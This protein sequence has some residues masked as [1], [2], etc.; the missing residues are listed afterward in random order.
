[1]ALGVGANTAIFSVVNAVLLRPLPYDQGDQLVVLHHGHGDALANDMGF[2][3]K[4]IGDYRRGRSFTD[5]V[6]FHQ[7]FFNLLGRT[8]P[9]R[10]STGVVGK[11]IEDAERRRPESQAEPCGRGRLRLHERQSATKKAIHLRLFPRLGLKPNPQRH[12]HHVPPLSTLNVRW[13]AYLFG[14]EVATLSAHPRA[15]ETEERQG[16]KTARNRSR[17]PRRELG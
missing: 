2:S 3:V 1:M 10:V 9:E 13:P 15:D 17:P 6:E 5:I 16:P 14:Q 8:E 11:R 4:D 12:C 7:M